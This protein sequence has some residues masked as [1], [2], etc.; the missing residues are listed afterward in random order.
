[1]RRVAVAC[2]VA[3]CVLL[4]IMV[5]CQ[6]D[7][8]AIPMTPLAMPKIKRRVFVPPNMM[9]ERQVRGQYTIDGGLFDS[10][11]N[12]VCHQ[13]F[14]AS[15]VC[16]KP[17]MMRWP[18][19]EA[20]YTPGTDFI[21][22]S[23]SGSG[24]NWQRLQR[25]ETAAPRNL[26]LKRMLNIFGRMERKVR[27]AVVHLKRKHPPLI[28]GKPFR[29]YLG[30]KKGLA[31]HRDAGASSMA[32]HGDGTFAFLQSSDASRKGGK[33]GEGGKKA[34]KSAK[35][36][37]SKGGQTANEEIPPL[38]P[39]PM[40]SARTTAG[41]CIVAD[42]KGNCICVD[43][44][45]LL[46]KPKFDTFGHEMRGSGC[47]E[48][49]KHKRYDSSWGGKSWVIQHSP[50]S[51]GWCG[52]TC[53]SGDAQGASILGNECPDQYDFSLIQCRQTELSDEDIARNKDNLQVDEPVNIGEIESQGEKANVPDIHKTSIEEKAKKS[54]ENEVMAAGVVAV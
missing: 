39:T 53:I 15:G 49:V 1:M 44:C 33:G 34:Q 28:S 13:Q 21:E 10:F 19:D 14:E 26:V 12:G 54:I 9:T 4:P 46:T 16:S 48:C 50:I 42:R 45:A 5:K 11:K 31:Q 3:L 22:T 35:A 41:R 43:P 51:C 38:P 7:E 52:N 36:K 27:S 24:D 32:R 20:G 37:K 23:S 2:C 17:C 47:D 6:I 8:A 29:W 18:Q 40:A 25:R 30:R